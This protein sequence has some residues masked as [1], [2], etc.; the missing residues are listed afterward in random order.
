MRFS[1]RL[2]S[3]RYLRIPPLRR[4]WAR[5]GG[6]G[7]RTSS[8]SMSSPNHSK[9]SCANNANPERHGN[10]RYLP[11]V[12]RPAGEGTGA[13]RRAGAARPPSYGFDSR[14]GARKTP[15]N[16]RTENHGG[17]ITFWMAAGRKWRAGH[18]CADVDALPDS[19]LESGDQALLPGAAAEFRSGTHFR[20]L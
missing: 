2:R 17:A 12:R 1:W 3:R 10:V 4:R 18:L 16:A 19:E 8:A 5:G 6:S 9:K 20:A 15:A 13:F 14:L 7:R 11:G